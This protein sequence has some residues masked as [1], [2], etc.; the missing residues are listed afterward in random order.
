MSKLARQLKAKPQPASKRQEPLWK[1]PGVDGVTQSLLG[2]F[3]QCRER[4]RVYAIEGL[5]PVEQ[6]NHRIE[7]GQMW[8]ICE[9]TLAGEP[10]G[11]WQQWLSN[12]AKDLCRKYPL[13]QE[14]VQHWYNV[15]KVQFPIY[16]DYW[17]KHQDVKDR[18]PL[19]QEQVFDV[20][21]KLSSG[22]IVRLRGK[23]D[24][25]DLIGKGKN[26]GVYLMEN[27]TKGD[28]NEQQLQRQLSSGFDW[29][30]MFYLVALTTWEGKTRD[31]PRNIAGVRYNVVRRP[32]SGGKGSIVRHKPSKSNPTGE[33]AEEFYNRLAGIIAEDPGYS[34]MRWRVEITPTDLLRFCQECLDPILEQLCQWWDWIE[35]AYEENRNPFENPVHFRYPYGVYNM[36]TEGGTAELDEYL[37]TG[38]ALGLERAGSLFGEL[39]DA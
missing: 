9:E 24:S 12:Y 13:Q 22:R 32:L 4:F 8:H 30:T 6:F 20:P 27:K 29:Q 36:L 5:R 28:I 3:L 19:L 39:S 2:R 33:T 15:C 31:Y 26:A 34:F 21:Y 18:T 23:W 16:V 10:K 17:A 7:Y 14:Q 1:G 35:D 37:N 11:D 25:V 38:S